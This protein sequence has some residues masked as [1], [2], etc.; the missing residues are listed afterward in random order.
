VESD[1]LVALDRKTGDQIWRA[2]GISQAWNTPLVVTA[3]SGRQELVIATQG[4]VLAFEPETGKPLWSCDTNITWYMVPSM[5][6]ADGIVYCLGGRSGVAGL[7]VRTG[8]EGDVTD[9]HRLWTSNKGSNVTS[10][11]YHD[12]HLYWMHEQSGIA[13]C[14]KAETGE[15]VYEKRLERAGQVYSSALLANGRVYYLT[16]DGKT[17]VLAAK[18]EFELLSVNNLSDRSI[19]N[20]SPAVDGNKLLIRSDKFLYCLGKRG[21]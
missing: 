14:A 20:G 8:G 16:R 7:A 6:A 10:P 12:G 19:F 4:K 3:K 5:V 1:S 9:T 21:E 11:V 17:F 13:Y 15:I 18:P 2:K